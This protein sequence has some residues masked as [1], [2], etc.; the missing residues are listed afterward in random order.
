MDSLRLNPQRQKLP[1]ASRALSNKLDTY[2]EKGL[3]EEK[4]QA[5]STGNNPPHPVHKTPARRTRSTI[6]SK[7]EALSRTFQRVGSITAKAIIPPSRA[8][9][10]NLFRSYKMVDKPI[11]RAISHSEIGD[12]SKERRELSPVDV[13]YF[14]G[15]PPPIE[16]P[17]FEGLKLT[18]QSLSQRLPGRFAQVM[19]EMIL[20]V[21]VLDMFWL[22]HSVVF[23]ADETTVPYS[24]LELPDEEPFPYLPIY[25][26][27]R[28]GDMSAQ[29]L[30]RNR[31][32]SEFAEI[33]MMFPQGPQR[34]GFLEVFPY[35][36]AFAVIRL[37]TLTF[38]RSGASFS[39]MFQHSLFEN[40]VY[41]MSGIVPYPD[42]ITKKRRMIF[43]SVIPGSSAADGSSGSKAF[44]T[45]GAAKSS[46]NDQRAIV[47]AAAIFELFPVS[48]SYFRDDLDVEMTR[49]SDAH[50]EQRS[51]QREAIRNI[52]VAKTRL[53]GKN[54]EVS[55]TK[56]AEGTEKGETGEL[57]GRD[58]GYFSR[59]KIH[60]IEDVKINT[61]FKKGFEAVA[62]ERDGPQVVPSVVKE[63]KKIFSADEIVERLFN[64]EELKPVTGDVGKIALE[65]PHT[66][67]PRQKVPRFSVPPPQ[68]TRPRPFHNTERI[69]LHSFSPLLG[70]YLKITE[71]P[72]SLREQKSHRASKRI[73]LTSKRPGIESISRSRAVPLPA[74]PFADP[75]SSQYATI[76]HS[77]YTGRT[78]RREFNQFRRGAY[79][80]RQSIRQ[81]LDVEKEM[82]GLQQTVCTTEDQ[83]VRVLA[84]RIAEIHATENMGVVPDSM[85]K[86]VAPATKNLRE[87]QGGVEMNAEPGNEGEKF[88]DET[89]NEPVFNVAL[90]PETV[91]S[92]V[93]TRRR[94]IAQRAKETKEREDIVK[95]WK[96]HQEKSLKKFEKKLN[97]NQKVVEQTEQ[98]G[99]I[100]N[101][102]LEAVHSSQKRSPSR[103]AYTPVLKT[104]VPRSSGARS[105]MAR[106]AASGE[107]K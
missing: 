81:A 66:Q 19:D 40:V 17:I 89:V 35:V 100:I 61:L 32:A 51:R 106:L 101:H 6:S 16:I 44:D 46:L 28:H 74:S 21:F 83:H 73:I 94:E 58:I 54:D 43:Q 1:A 99:S 68:V 41:L 76:G 60:K 90:P 36:V 88:G 67:D 11:K 5:N 102:I 82:I 3:V 25:L 96:T 92:I 34:D 62:E 103:S 85:P 78:N 95:R 27:P 38:P 71:M 56:P 23:M 18:L 64:P 15:Q 42:T 98:Q 13:C 59:L 20:K 72:C 70:H 79:H 37:F 91:Q 104:T 10:E 75:K 84:R 30:L 53:L 77:K 14:P 24:R 107:S 7:A 93:M 29:Q 55:A 80:D 49:L 50:L 33:L 97:P 47:Q 48:E 4:P 31:I 65:N 22:T 8:L 45:V 63:E 26:Q 87:V 39:A 9:A 69:H 2:F 105:P 52:E 57:Q 86:I 12:P